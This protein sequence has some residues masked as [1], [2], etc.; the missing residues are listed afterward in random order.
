MKFGLTRYKVPSA[1]LAFVFVTLLCGPAQAGTMGF[2]QF[3]VHGQPR[4]L[5]PGSVY[6]GYDEH[7]SPANELPEEYPFAADGVLFHNSHGEYSGPWGPW[8]SWEGWAVSNRADTTTPGFSNQYSAITGGGVFGSANYAI[9]YFPDENVDDYRR[10]DIAVAQT[11]VPGRYGFYLTNTTYAYLTMRDGDGYGFTL[12]FTRADNDFFRLAI[13]GL[14]A[15]GNAIAGLDPVNFYLA[16]F[17]Q[18]REPG[19]V[20]GDYIVN[21]WTWVDLAKLVTGGASQLRFKFASSDVDPTFGIN[22]PLYVAMDRAVVPE[23]SC[24]ALAAVG[25]LCLWLRRRFV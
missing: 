3:T 21:Q 13:S 18:S 4:V 6:C 9:G 16:D 20:Q 1:S 2:E 19:A 14:D 8:S 7:P 10:V 12:P 25:F 22:T 15:F 17:R 11:G 23:P 5:A 24:W